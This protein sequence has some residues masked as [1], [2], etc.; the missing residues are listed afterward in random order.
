MLADYTREPLIVI[1]EDEPI[2]RVRALMRKLDESIAVIADENKKFKG[3]LTRRDVSVVTSAKTSL[4]AKDLSRDFPIATID[5][6]LE[7]LLDEMSKHRVWEVV[8]VDNYEDMRVQGVVTLRD[9]IGKFIDKGYKPKASTVS[10]I[11]STRDLSLLIV[12]PETRITKIWSR[13][14]LKSLP[15]VIV[16]KSL[17]EPVPVGIIT[18][19]DLVRKGRW[20]FHR[21]S[22][23][24]VVSPAKAKRI[25]TRG[26]V[27]ATPDTPIEYVARFMAENDAPLLPVIND[28]GKVV[29]V[30]TQEDVVR[31][32]IEGA[33]PGAVVVKPKITVKPVPEAERITFM[34][35]ESMLS[36]VLV[37]RKVGREERPPSITAEDI[38]IKELPAITVNDSVE[39]ARNVMLR[40]KSNYIVVTDEK[41]SIVGVVSKW[42]MIKA[43]SAKG[44]LW[45]RKI[46][47]RFFIDYVMNK[48]PPRVKR[49]ETIESIA[50][51][52]ISSD[53][54]V[55]I[56]EDDKGNTVGFVTK[57][58]VVE[59]FVKNR[60]HAILVEHIMTPARIGVVHPHHSLAH[61]VNKMKTFRLDAITV[62]EGDR[63]HGIVSANR[64]PFV[65]YEDRE[66]GGSRRLIWVRKLVKGAARKG[67]YVKVT[68]LVAID[69]A[70]KVE[71][72][73]YPDQT[74]TTA[75]EKMRGNNVDGIPV[76]DKDGRVIGTV[77]KYDILREIIRE[78][79]ISLKEE[80]KE[81]IV[82]QK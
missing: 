55:A 8:V 81:T 32:Y 2:T 53:S 63:I 68:P 70:A 56:I 40:T 78:A 72:Y 62:A 12:D 36:Q 4:R 59:A 76:R 20:R 52:M 21:E 26:V 25:M 80:K 44:P 9:I 60:G 77:C 50:L 73:V 64:L 57:D 74:L 35:A 29:G 38:M 34:K 48:N 51:K 42:N 17:D 23:S 15:A 18:T 49:E 43:I 31:A 5:M 3:Y 37:E 67:R 16:V 1:K 47:D 65:A 33:K 11:M 41:G 61:V 13:L 14:V 10:E 46:H 19:A 30:V 28:E 6:P 66:N 69:L 39:H 45:K 22:E 75:F 7:K 24:K 82:K 71:D 27:V 54:E 58:A 79:S